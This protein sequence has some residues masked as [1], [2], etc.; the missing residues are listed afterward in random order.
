MAEITFLS[1][2]TYKESSK[3]FFVI[4]FAVITWILQV[5]VLNHIQCFDTACNFMLLGVIYI[6]LIL[7][8]V[9][10]VLF[11]II[12]SFFSASILYDHTFYFSYPLVGLFAGLLTKN[13]FSDELLFFIV[14]SFTLTFPYELLN[15]WQ[16]SIKNPLNIQDRWLMVSLYGALINLVIAP[17]YYLI[18]NFFT[19]KSKI[20]KQ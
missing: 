15:G 6:G 13:L 16:Y 8:P 19:K 20:R 5:S 10:G 2:K 11:G 9:Y 18:M 12:C 14:L 7:G 3:Y 4:V 17:F 1:N